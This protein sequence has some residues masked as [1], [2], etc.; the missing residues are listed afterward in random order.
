MT[1]ETGRQRICNQP[2]VQL[3]IT[4]QGLNDYSLQKLPV[5]KAHFNVR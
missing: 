2:L 4:T 3:T 5:A 1:R